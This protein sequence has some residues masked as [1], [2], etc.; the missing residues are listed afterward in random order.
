MEGPFYE[1]Q[2]PSVKEI[3][4]LLCIDIEASDKTKDIIKKKVTDYYKN[5][6]PGSWRGYY[7]F[8]YLKILQL[9]RSALVEEKDNIESS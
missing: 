1:T 5:R 2:G 9:I 6:E 8:D 3:I 4:N 7:T